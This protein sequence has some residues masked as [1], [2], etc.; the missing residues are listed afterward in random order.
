MCIER[1]DEL[2][3]HMNMRRMGKQ[4][5]VQMEPSYDQICFNAP[6]EVG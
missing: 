5:F 6:S 3:Y 4:E 2:E 1:C